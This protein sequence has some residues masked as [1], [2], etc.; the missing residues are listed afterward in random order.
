ML[1]GNSING[2]FL[3]DFGLE[4]YFLKELD[5]RF[6]TYDVFNRDRLLGLR[7]FLLAVIA[8][9]GLRVI[10]EPIPFQPVLLPGG[11]GRLRRLIRFFLVDRLVLLVLRVVFV[12]FVEQVEN[13]HY[14]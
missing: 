12:Q 14:G 2:L 5:F 9:F 11:L 3:D 13:L 6:K 4:L 1:L 7:L 10:D 8:V